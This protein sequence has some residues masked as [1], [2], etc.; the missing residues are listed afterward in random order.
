M[1]ESPR[2]VYD[3]RDVIRAL[4]DN[5]EMLEVSERWARNMVTAFCRIDGRRSA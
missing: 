2:K 5:A 1:P 3:V 4:V